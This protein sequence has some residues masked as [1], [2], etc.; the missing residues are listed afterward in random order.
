MHCPSIVL[1]YAN[2]CPC[3]LHFRL[4][5]CYIHT[6][7]IVSFCIVNRFS[8]YLPSVVIRL[9]RVSCDRRISTVKCYRYAVVCSAMLLV[10]PCV[11]FTGLLSLVVSCSCIQFSV[12]LYSGLFHGDIALRAAVVPRHLSYYACT[13]YGLI[14][15]M[16]FISKS[17]LV[18]GL[19]AI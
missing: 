17:L 8:C 4:N 2:P 3:S 18:L 6:H 7:R 10:S 13:P 14:Y 12:V 15:K 11:F 16:T 5:S 9:Q 19:Q 1:R